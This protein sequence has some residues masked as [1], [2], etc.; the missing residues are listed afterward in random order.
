MT[1]TI[2]AHTDQEKESILAVLQKLA[3]SNISSVEYALKEAVRTN[4]SLEEISKIYCEKYDIN[5][6]ILKSKTR[7]TGWVQHR[8]I[9]MYI[10]NVIFKKT[11]SET[12]K[13]F[14]RDHSTAIHAVDTIEGYIQVDKSFKQ[15]VENALKLY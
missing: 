9:I 3:E 2:T 11:F 6:T 13:Y 1:I 12:G 8:Q 7:T 14:R 10:M 5:E 4:N 15:R